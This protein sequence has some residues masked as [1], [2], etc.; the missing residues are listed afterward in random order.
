MENLGLKIFT[1]LSKTK[2]WMETS[3]RVYPRLRFEL[4]YSVYL[5]LRVGLEYFA[6]YIQD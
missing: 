6:V 4:K 1:C 2:D 5:G 3:V